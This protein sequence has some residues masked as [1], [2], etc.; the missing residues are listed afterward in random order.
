MLMKKHNPAL[1]A[2]V[3]LTLI[4]VIVIITLIVGSTRGARTVARA[5]A[6]GHRLKKVLSPRSVELLQNPATRL[7]EARRLGETRTVEAVPMLRQF[8]KDKDPEVRRT[9][10]WSLGEIGDK[11][12]VHAVLLRAYDEETT[13]RIET[14][15]AL[16]KLYGFDAHQGL[17]DM[18]GDHDPK[19]RIAAVRSFERVLKD[20]QA[21]KAVIGALGD[22]EAEVRRVA[23]DI[24]ATSDTEDA[25]WAFVNT[26]NDKDAALRLLAAKELAKRRGVAAFHGLSR[27]LGHSDK[28]VREATAEAILAVGKPLIPYLKKEL[29]NAKTAEGKAAAARLLARMGEVDVAPAILSLLKH[30]KRSKHNPGDVD[31]VREAV[32]DALVM[33]G[34]PALG[35]MNAEVIDGESSRDAEEVVADACVKIGKPAAKVITDHILKWKLYHDPEEMKLWIGTL[36]KIGDPAAMPA[37]NR[38]LSQDIDGMDKLVAETRAAIEKRSGQKLPNPKP[39]KVAFHAEISEVESMDLAEVPVRPLTKAVKRIPD[40][41][42]VKL[43]L[44]EAL[45]FP[46]GE[47]SR[48]DLMVELTRENGKWVMECWGRAPRYNGR[49]QPGRVTEKVSSSAKTVLF[50]EQA[51]LSD[52]DVPGGYGEYEI[53][54]VPGKDGMDATYKGHYCY[55]GL[56]GKAS[57]RC[58]EGKIPDPWRD[59]IPVASGEHPRLL[60]RESDLPALCARARTPLGRRIIRILLKK[61][62][63]GKV[64]DFDKH[65]NYVTN[66]MSGMDRAIAQGMLA[67]VFDDP[68]HGKRAAQT[69]LIR[70]I[71]PAYAGE[72]GEKQGPAMPRLGFGYDLTYNYLTPEEKEIAR[73][74]VATLWDWTKPNAKIMMGEGSWDGVTTAVLSLLREKGPWDVPLPFGPGQKAVELEPAKDLLCEGIPVT[75]LEPGEMLK[76]LLL[77]TGFEKITTQDPL[78]KLGGV[79]RANPTEGTLLEYG[80]KTFSFMPLPMGAAFRTAGL[81]AKKECIK[82]PGAKADTCSY[83]YGIVDVPKAV[84]VKWDC[85]HPLGFRMS[86]SWINGQEVDN[87]TTVMLKAGMY[88]VMVQV[89]G[90]NLSPTFMVTQSGKSRAVLKA[91]EFVVELWNKDKARHAQ[92][93][94]MGSVWR[95][96]HKA[97]RAIRR[98]SYE[99]LDSLWKVG[100]SGRGPGLRKGIS[101]RGTVAYGRVMGAPLFRDA[102]L[103]FV[104]CPAL[105][106]SAMNDDMLCYL[107]TAAPPELRP[108]L[109]WEFNRRYKDD[110][111]LARMEG[112]HL[113]AAF[114]NY[115]FGV[116]PKHPDEVIPRNP[117]DAR[118]GSYGFW[119]GVKKGGFISTLFCRSSDPAHVSRD[120]PRGG[121]FSLHGLG[122]TWITVGQGGKGDKFD[123]IVDVEGS[124]AEGKGRILYFD[125]KED[126]SGVAGVD[127]SNV[128][129]EGAD[130]RVEATR[131]YAVDYSGKSGA[132]ALLAVVDKIQGGGRKTW[133]LFTGAHEFEVVNDKEFVVYTVAP[134]KGGQRA[135]KRN[136]RGRVVSPA[137]AKVTA[138]EGMGAGRKERDVP[139]RVLNINTGE[140]NPEFFVVMTVQRE[141]T[142]EFAV[143]GE[144][145]AAKVRVGGQTVG[146]SGE[147]IV[148][149]AP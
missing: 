70:F 59:G 148:L 89:W 44:W 74:K 135:D 84:G 88:R 131:H 35:H 66:W 105:F 60:F 91:H 13:V 1:L 110:D 149:A 11:E 81:G 113:V 82:I 122:S 83:L 25:T 34:E 138:P 38:A 48:P 117:V 15:D 69:A 99:G 45:R 144:G 53:T 31:M 127:V 119:S 116:E 85:S 3:G 98:I 16:S 118:H 136:L 17:V 14:A 142:P 6:Q 107:M 78:E 9:C 58:R 47:G 97:E 120:D 79:A 109:V 143:D 123:N 141:G 18:L 147:K 71:T 27:A 41:G 126:G 146:F 46:F 55:K 93:G 111:K 95:Y 37:L 8:T 124:G 115:P 23:L 77:A 10:V 43:T 133:T 73:Q 87:G 22:D 62:A 51:M 103:P 104:E 139:S 32:S 49:H 50:L 2:I 68:M 145:L 26:L 75:T 7:A 80:E 33:M 52:G 4:G 30:M 121:Y 96:I 130:V 65:L 106:W 63:G 92:T 114:C 39:D 21:L 101:A 61:L 100:V 72:H 108:A 28:A 64:E 140:A 5:A 137:D 54:M 20:K 42:V 24:L 134:G 128:Y 36:G 56:D 90:S 132:P 76:D 94:E 40:N 29:A 19:V 86:R 12:A 129:S 102:E 57:V 125:P 67:A 112:H